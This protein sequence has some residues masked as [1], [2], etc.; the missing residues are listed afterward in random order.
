[1]INAKSKN[2]IEARINLDQQSP[3]EFKIF[4]TQVNKE[5]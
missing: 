3:D 4:A 2:K 1:M 5:Q